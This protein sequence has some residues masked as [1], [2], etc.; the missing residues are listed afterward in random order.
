MEQVL[1]KALSVFDK[2]SSLTNSILLLAKRYL[3]A[4]CQ[5]VYLTSHGFGCVYVCMCMCSTADVSPD[6][7]DGA[8]LVGLQKRIEEYELSLSDRIQNREEDSTEV[9]AELASLRAVLQETGALLQEKRVL[10][11]QCNNLYCDANDFRFVSALCRGSFATVYLARKIDVGGY[12]AV[13]VMEKAMVGV[14]STAV[15]MRFIP[16]LTL[17]S[18]IYC[19][20]SCMRS[21]CS[22][23]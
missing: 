9:R 6:R 10:L 19:L 15:C 2:K 4:V 8:M 12:Y 5:C 1:V 22:S 13:K 18:A 11:R 7:S 23:M 3:T 21:A 16:V 20:C 14:G 17:L